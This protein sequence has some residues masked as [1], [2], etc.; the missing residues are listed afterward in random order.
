MGSARSAKLLQRKLVRS[1]FLVFCRRIILPL[2]FVASKSYK[3]PHEH[4]LLT[5]IIG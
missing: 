4:S 2:T 1:C 5:L 3:F